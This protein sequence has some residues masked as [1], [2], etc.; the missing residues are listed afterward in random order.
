MRKKTI[1]GFG[2]LLILILAAAIVFFLNFKTVVVSGPSMQPTFHNGDRLLASR[3][4][5]LVGDVAKKDI[6]VVHSA[7]DKLYMIKRVAYMDG[8]TVDY[9]NIPDEWPLTSGPYVVPKGTVYVLGDN[10]TNSEDSRKYGPVPKKKI[11]GKIIVL[12]AAWKASLKVGMVAAVLFFVLVFILE[13]VRK[14]V[15]VRVAEAE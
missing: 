5:W 4:Y 12:P 11:L 6:V 14:P 1:T 10:W 2:M 7:D 8:E 3:A 9:Q 15:P 13:R